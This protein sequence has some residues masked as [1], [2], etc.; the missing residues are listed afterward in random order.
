MADTLETARKLI[1]G[2]LLKQPFMQ[3]LGVTL[4]EVAEGRVELLCDLKPELTQHGGVAHGGVIGA[5]ADNAAGAAAGTL[6]LPDKVTV[7]AEYKINFVSPGAGLRLRALGQVIKPGK[8]LIAVES[9]VYGVAAD[10]G[11]TLCAIALATMVP[12][13][14]PPRG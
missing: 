1:A 9:R 4:G 7:T 11:E 5:L 8:I 12:V 14:M 3:M 10:G 2:V 13:A 6:T